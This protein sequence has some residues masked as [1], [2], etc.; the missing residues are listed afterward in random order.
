MTEQND[1]ATQ[2]GIGA[3][4]GTKFTWPK[5]N[6]YATEGKFVLTPE[7]EKIWKKWISI[8]NQKMLPNGNYLGALYDIGYDKP[9][10][11]VIQ[12]T[13]TLFYAF[14]NPD[15]KGEVE[16]RGLGNGDY[17]VVDYINGKESGD[18]EC[19]QSQEFR[20]PSDKTC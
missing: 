9:E 11:H 16:L 5:D 1:F 4:L 6:P 10:A 13:D 2:V 20:S 3:V 14:Y 7:K 15:W 17:R 19:S 12:K 18:C 8:Y